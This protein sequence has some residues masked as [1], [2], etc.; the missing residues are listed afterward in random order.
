MLGVGGVLCLAF[1]FYCLNT[2]SPLLALF[3]GVVGIFSL[4]VWT[5]ETHL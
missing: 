3:A 4:V 2:G 1:C 5:L